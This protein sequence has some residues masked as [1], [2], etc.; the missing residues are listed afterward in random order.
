[1]RAARPL[2]VIFVRHG[3]KQYVSDHESAW[4]LTDAAR[5]LTLDLRSRL[6]REGLGPDLLLTSRW[7]HAVETAEILAG[8]SASTLI[9]GVTGL[10]PKTDDA[11][12]TRGAILREI[13]A[14]GLPLEG[15]HTVA[16]VGHHP[17]LEDLAATLIGGPLLPP[18][19]RLEAVVLVAESVRTLLLHRASVERRLC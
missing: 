1:V 7:R 6:V 3:E 13:R 18:L 12:F 11:F 16:V 14:S 19:E 8:S 2:R 4:P 9:L 5:G 10:T 17:R 15:A